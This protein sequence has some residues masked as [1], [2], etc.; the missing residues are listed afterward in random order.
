MR[1][2]LSSSRFGVQG[3][4]TTVEGSAIGVC[5]ARFV[6][7]LAVLKGKVVACVSGYFPDLGPERWLRFTKTPLLASGSS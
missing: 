1:F 4:K 6:R 7:D 2:A 5:A 3:S